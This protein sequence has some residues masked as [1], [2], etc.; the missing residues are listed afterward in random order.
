[1]T[2]TI[3]TKEGRI[4]SILFDFNSRVTLWLVGADSMTDY[5]PAMHDISQRHAREVI[6][7]DGVTSGCSVHTTNYRDAGNPIPSDTKRARKFAESVGIRFVDR[8]RFPSRQTEEEARADFALAPD[9]D[10]LEVVFCGAGWL[11]GTSIHA[12]T[13]FRA[14]PR[15]ETRGRAIVAERMDADLCVRCGNPVDHNEPHVYCDNCA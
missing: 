5:F 6:A 4:E 8:I 7:K 2:T 10:D 3:A 11:D 1:M 13:I 12:E 9:R 14:C 15:S